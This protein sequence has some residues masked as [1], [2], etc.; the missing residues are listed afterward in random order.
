MDISAAHS[1]LMDALEFLMK[2]CCNLFIMNQRWSGQLSN[3]RACNGLRLHVA[4]TVLRGLYSCWMGDCLRASRADQR[5]RLDNVS[6][7]V[8]CGKLFP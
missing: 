4:G 6:D 3:L 5:H 2:G 7:L 8:C 1:I